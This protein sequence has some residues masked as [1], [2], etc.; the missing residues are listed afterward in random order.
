MVNL[1]RQ[2]SQSLIFITQ[3]SRQLDINV[4]SQADCVVIK[5]LTELSKEFERKE[6][7]RLTDKARDEFSIAPGNKQRLSWVY[8][9][10][11]GGEVGLVENELP[12]FWRPAFCKSFFGNHP[13][14]IQ[15][16]TLTSRK[17][18]I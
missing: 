15:P 10:A 4:I 14:P 13:E 2:K 7:R 18:N 17:E 8:S 3:E 1:S 9:E 5:E 12:S 11:A 6:L 16:W